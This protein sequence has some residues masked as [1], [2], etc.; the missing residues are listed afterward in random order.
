[1]QGRGRAGRV[2]PAGG[3]LD[4]T[5]QVVRARPGE[6]R[7][8]RPPLPGGAGRAGA[9]GG[10]GPAARVGARADP[11]P[12]H[13]HQGARPVPGRGPRRAP[14]HRVGGQRSVATGPQAPGRYLTGSGGLHGWSVIV[15][16]SVSSLPKGSSTRTVITI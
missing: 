10:G 16:V 1:A 13:R 8:V 7:G 6:V 4:R 3:A 5:A 11:H 12:A 14:Q 2:V 15:A 9:G